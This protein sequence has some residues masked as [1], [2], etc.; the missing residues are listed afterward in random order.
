MPDLAEQIRSVIDAGGP[1]ISADE[2]M[3][4]SSQPTSYVARRQRVSMSR[5]AAVA[6]GAVLTVA[7][8]A[9]V[10]GVGF[11]TLPAGTPVGSAPLGPHDLTSRSFAV[12]VDQVT[13]TYPSTWKARQYLNDRTSFSQSVVFV[14]SQSLHDPCTTSHSTPPGP[15]QSTVCLGYAVRR[16]GSDGVYLE[17]S[18]DGA[19][20][21]AGGGPSTYPGSPV[22]VGG[23]PG[24]IDILRPGGCVSAGGSE[25]IDVV[26]DPESNS[27][28]YAQ[29]CLSGPDLNKSYSQ[30][31]SLLESTR[32]SPESVSP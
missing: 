27:G 6:W 30:F 12:G 32:F 5:R 23:Q 1:S 15:L 2:V 10:V 14:S 18:Y 29:A 11:A 25:S 20:G 8:A 31:L 26:V 9:L 16:L 17:W 28:W 19:P 13:F 4:R 3:S 22:T 7:L 24:I 21:P